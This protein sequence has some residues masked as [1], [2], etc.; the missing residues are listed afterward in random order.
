MAHD[1]TAC[2]QMGRTQPDWPVA[3]GLRLRTA[4]EDRKAA[5]HRLP[6]VRLASVGYQQLAARG[7]GAKPE[8]L[9]SDAT[10]DHFGRRYAIFGD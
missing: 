2:K 1:A 7:D 6:T 4:T 5:T 10:Y 9:V 3:V 8:L